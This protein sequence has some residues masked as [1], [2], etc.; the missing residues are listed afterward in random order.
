MVRGL[1]VKSDEK[2]VE[3]QGLLRLQKVCRYLLVT[4]EHPKIR[5]LL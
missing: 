4:L 3:D 2:Q 5:D 1:Q